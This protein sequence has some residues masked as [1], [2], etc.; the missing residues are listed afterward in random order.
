MKIIDEKGRLFG[1][2]NI[3][4]LIVVILL[5]GLIP[6][7]YF[8]YKIFSNRPKSVTSIIGS[9]FSTEIKLACNFSKVPIDVA[10][11]IAKGDKELDSAGK[12]I[13]EI[14]DL[15]PS[16]IYI[17]EYDLG[18]DNIIAKENQKFK[19]V[20]VTLKLKANVNSGKLYYKGC[21]AIYLGG[22]FRFCTNK[23]EIFGTIVEDNFKPSAYKYLNFC[24]TI[25]GLNPE[26]A[27]LICVGEKEYGDNNQLIAEIIRVDDVENDF[28][29]L[30]L[31]NI[32]PV[33]ISDTDKKQV[34][35]VAKLFCYA[36]ENGNVYFKGRKISNNS[37]VE[38]KLSKNIYNARINKYDSLGYRYVY[39]PVKVKF[40]EVS[41]DIVNLIRPQDKEEDPFTQRVMLRIIAVLDVAPSTIVYIKDD[42]AVSGTHP[43]LKD[44][45]VSAEILCRERKG[46]V[47]YKDF[48]IRIGMAFTFIS[49]KYIINGKLVSLE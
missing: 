42:K 26:E 12:I 19:N 43:V 27:R 29:M 49:D 17:D 31:N 44:V 39:V 8:G 47:Y 21:Y 9:E 46:L 38:L 32:T 40:S 5:L 6:M 35:L 7:V 45:L 14:T 16:E 4:D 20:V 15:G 2:I 13:A 25:K 24:L 34:S 48:P 23:Y 3:I 30:D 28:F 37:I 22:Q 41:L 10:K 11:L 33:Y 1:I 36:K 18:G